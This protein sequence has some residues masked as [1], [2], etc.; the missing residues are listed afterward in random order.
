MHVQRD[1]QCNLLPD[2]ERLTFM[3]KFIRKTFLDEIQQLINVFKEDI[4]LRGLR[5]LWEE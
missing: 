1:A 5:P 4:S 2:A 3:S